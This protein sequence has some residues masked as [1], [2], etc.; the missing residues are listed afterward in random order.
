[1]KAA[2]KEKKIKYLWWA[3]LVF[4]FG[5]VLFNL[6]RVPIPWLD[7]SYWLDVA[8]NLSN[9]SYTSKIWHYP[10]IEEKFL[11]YLPFQFFYDAAFMKFLP[12][13]VFWYRLPHVLAFAVALV[14]LFKIYRKNQELSFLAT[15]VLVAV[16]M[17]DKGIYDCI[18]NSRGEV[19]SLMLLAPA[20]YLFQ[21]KKSAIG[22][23]L[24]LSALFFN[25]PSIWVIVGVLML[26]IF[27]REN[28][29]NKVL[30]S[31][32]FAVP[33]LAFL[34]YAEFDFELIKLQ[35][36]DHGKEH[37]AKD[38]ILA[39]HFWDR[40]M[41]FYKLQPWVPFL[42]LFIT[43]YCVYAII[44][45][46]SIKQ[47]PLE[48]TFLANQLYWLL[49]LAPFYRYNS[50]HILLMFILLPKPLLLLKQQFYDGLAVKKKILAVSVGGLLLLPFAVLVEL[51]FMSR[52]LA[53]IV[54][55]EERDPNK[56]IAWLDN[57]FDKNK[58][59]LLID[60]SL[61]HYYALAN[62]NIDY[63]ITYSVY[64]YDF[65]AYDEVYLVSISPSQAKEAALVDTY[66]LEK[67]TFF[68]YDFNNVITYNG[69]KIY[70]IESVKQ[71]NQLQT[72]YEKYADGKQ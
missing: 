65:N 2:V 50:P 55:R 12:H 6:D 18:R 13:G 26:Y 29:K 20:T 53:G 14:F 10:R 1:L 52:N 56:A 9:G 67:A 31:V 71:F 59:I 37:M 57:H 41:P 39:G 7:E 30:I 44:K 17:N 22:V 36:I 49:V 51:P 45:Q 54:Q 11:A 62:E 63:T 69:L 28:T 19:L 48:V 5:L 43:G 3:Y 4:Y 34:I 66:T 60:N 38:N 16:F 21:Q 42:N 70:K 15:I 40:Y 32:V 72:G 35:L 58:K 68:G 33:V 8:H 64:K 24:L 25:H 46:K 47:L 61:A 27:F 23:T